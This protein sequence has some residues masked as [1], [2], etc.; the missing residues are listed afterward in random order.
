RRPATG[1]T[2]SSPRGR[3]RSLPPATQKFVAEEAIR[4]STPAVASLPR[5]PFA[6]VEHPRRAC[7]HSSHLSYCAR[8]RPSPPVA[9]GPGGASRAARPETP[10]FASPEARALV[11]APD[12]SPADRQ[13]DPGRR[14]AE[15]L[16]FL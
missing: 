5:Q 2:R 11:D 3:L 9:A 15:L 4:R 8:L 1:H 12:R 13:I 10:I 6:L 14:P 7:A 16:T